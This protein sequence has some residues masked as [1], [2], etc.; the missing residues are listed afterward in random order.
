MN[1]LNLQHYLIKDLF[2]DHLLDPGISFSEPN[3]K[4][5]DVGC[6]T[7]CVESV[8]RMRESCD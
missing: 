6:G 8:L 7:G 3:L 4:I 5:A 1:R 2:D